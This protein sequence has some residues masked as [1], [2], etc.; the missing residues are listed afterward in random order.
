[1]E[2]KPVLDGRVA[3]V[4]GAGRGIG[5]AAALALADCGA[6]VAALSQSDSAREV[7]R[8]IDPQGSRAIGLMA[9]VSRQSDLDA[10]FA[11]ARSRLGPIDILVNCA[12]MF[13]PAGNLWEN[14]PDAWMRTVSVN[15]G[16]TFRTMRLALPEMIA[17]KYGRVINVAGG[18]AASPLPRFTAYGS[19]KAAV[20]RLSETAAVEVRPHGVTVNVI[21]PGS[22]QTDMR[23]RFMAA[24]GEVRSPVEMDLPVSLILFLASEAAGTVTGRFVHIKDDYRAWPDAVPPADLYTMRRIDPWILRS[25]ARG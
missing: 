5:R 13:E 16:G 19:S 15:L 18:G 6:R 10:A 22:P 4:T 21:A 23:E 2:Q 11:A 12:G 8:E 17:R 14:D 7:A 3:L 24:G 20:V 9:D 1:M 25:L